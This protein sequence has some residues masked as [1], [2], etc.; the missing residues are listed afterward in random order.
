MVPVFGQGV[1]FDA[2][3]ERRKTQLKIQVDALRYQNMRS[4]AKVIAGEGEA[5]IA[6]W[7]EQGELEFFDEFQ[8]LT[9]H[10]A[11]HCLLGRDFR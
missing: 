3:P 9:L 4:Y 2:P 8:Q 5:W 6:D 11:M 1:I 10:T 7:G